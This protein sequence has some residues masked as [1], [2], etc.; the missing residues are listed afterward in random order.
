M[1]WRCNM[2]KTFFLKSIGERIKKLREDLSITQGELAE[3]AGYT[4]H[5]SI[6]KIESGAIDLPQSKIELI[7]SALN[8]TPAY[9]MGWKDDPR[10]SERS[11]QFDNIFPIQTQRIPMLG[12]IACGKP[13]FANEERESYVQAG[14]N[15]KADFCLTARG[16]SMIGARIHDGDI[17]FCRSQSIVDNGEIAA[18]II[19]EEAT[20]KR[21]YYYPEKKKLVLQAENPKYEPYVYIG[22]ELDEITILGKA[23][24]FQSDIK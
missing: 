10:I 8:T 4:S 12:D 1:Q 23:I 5:S 7:A 13:I 22:S 14:I 3:K 16:D 6:A 18:V 2:D 21:V 20:L 19:G 24:A 17:V 9:L 15:I 11:M